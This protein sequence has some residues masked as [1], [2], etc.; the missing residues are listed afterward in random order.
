[1]TSKDKQIAALKQDR[2]TWM[3]LKGDADVTISKLQTNIRRLR[4]ELDLPLASPEF[5]QRL[6]EKWHKEIE[7]GLWQQIQDTTRRA[8]KA[9]TRT[10]ELQESNEVLLRRVVTEIERGDR[11][12]FNNDNERLEKENAA[13]KA[14]CDDYKFDA[15]Y[16][17]RELEKEQ[18][19]HQHAVAN[20]D[21]WY[22][23][24][25]DLYDELEEKEARIAELNVK[26]EVCGSARAI[27]AKRV[28]ESYEGG[29][30][31]SVTRRRHR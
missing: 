3:R 11:A 16:F 18:G 7:P 14:D 25:L 8:E 2:D 21:G 19:R 9:E 12:F 30:R 13:L 1:M 10:K 20:L 26:L 5:R 31:E 6:D 22:A 28:S 15:E 24:A 23:T 4:R 17:F 27:L 29:G